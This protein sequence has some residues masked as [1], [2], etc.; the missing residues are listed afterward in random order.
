M[1]LL[2]HSPEPVTN[3]PDPVTNSPKPVQSKAHLHRSPRSP[4]HLRVTG[5]E[6]MS[7]LVANEKQKEVQRH[8]LLIGLEEKL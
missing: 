7:H 3:S 4:R 5:G 6:A 2:I 8:S 1:V